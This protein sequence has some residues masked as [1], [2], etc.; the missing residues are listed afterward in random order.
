MAFTLLQSRRVL[1]YPRNF[2]LDYPPVYFFYL[3]H[4][5]DVAG[6]KN[7]INDLKNNTF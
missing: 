6:R 7:K 5:A 2:F 3:P 4:F 1:R